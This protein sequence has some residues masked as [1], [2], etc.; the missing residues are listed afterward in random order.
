MSMLKWGRLLYHYVIQKALES[1]L[2]VGNTLVDMYA[3]C[4]SLI[5]AEV[6]FNR[7]STQNNV[8]WNAM[9]AGHAQ[10]GYFKQAVQWFETMQSLCLKPTS[11]TF[12]SVLAACT[13][14]G[15]VEDGYGACTDGGKVKDGYGYLMSTLFNYGFSPGIEH[16]N[17]M[18]DLLGRTGYIK[19]AEG[20]LD[21]MPALPNING[22]MSLLTSCVLY[23]NVNVGRRS[24][25]EV[26]K[27]DPDTSAGHILMLNI[28]ADA[29]MWGDVDKLCEKWRSKCTWR[30]PGQAFLEVDGHLLKFVVGDFTQFVGK[31][32]SFKI[33]NLHSLLRGGGYVPHSE[34]IFESTF[35]GDAKNC[36]L[37]QRKHEYTTVH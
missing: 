16:F 1:D 19:D 27:L 7:L 10:H 8:S 14:G 20:L 17:C 24:F 18:V 4:G 2:G 9:I 15:K 26:A 31:D 3:R 32:V 13:H 25:E 11:H 34:T 36:Y 5:E 37:S 29:Q 12:V 33:R 35:A 6:I 28:Y 21:T 23:G 30:K 22:W